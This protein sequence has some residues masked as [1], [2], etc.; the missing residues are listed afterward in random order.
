MYVLCYVSTAVPYNLYFPDLSRPSLSYTVYFFCCVVYRIFGKGTTPRFIIFTL[1]IYVFKQLGTTLY[2]LAARQ[3]SRKQHHTHA[4]GSL[5]ALYYCSFL[6]IVAFDIWPCNLLA[7]GSLLLC[8][9]CM[10]PRVLK[11]RHLQRRNMT[12]YAYDTISHAVRFQFAL[13]PLP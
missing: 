1:F 9:T 8:D 11:H 4:C 13:A 7:W 3:H 2:K 12:S 5:S 6:S 10:L